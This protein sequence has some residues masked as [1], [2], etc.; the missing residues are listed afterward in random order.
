MRSIGRAVRQVRGA[1]Q[2][3][4]RGDP[5]QH[6]EVASRDELGDMAAAF[7]EMVAYLNRM[8]EAA[9]RIA[10][11]DLAADVAPQGERDTLG[12]AFAAMARTCASWWAASP[13]RRRR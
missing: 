2:G 12:L 4:A 10:G 8:A 13:A 5:E 3:I 1:A 7:R 6:I 9:Q 11:G